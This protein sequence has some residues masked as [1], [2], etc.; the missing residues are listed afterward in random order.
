MSCFHGWENGV[1]ES[2]GFPRG[3]QKTPRLLFPVTRNALSIF[4]IPSPVTCMVTFY[5]PLILEWEKAHFSDSHKTTCL[6]SGHRQL[7]QPGKQKLFGPKKVC[8]LETKA[9]VM[10]QTGRHGGPLPWKH[11]PQTACPGTVPTVASLLQTAV[12]ES[13]MSK[14]PSHFP[15]S[16]TSKKYKTRRAEREANKK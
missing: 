6:V 3:S 14:G 4:I 9:L 11:L 5:V 12:L 2:W 7:C 8:I 16:W 1:Y 13:A 15:F 10:Q